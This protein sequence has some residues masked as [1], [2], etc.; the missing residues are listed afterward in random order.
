[1][2]F[3]PQSWRTEALRHALWLVA[4]AGPEYAL[5]AAKRAERESGGV[6]VGL[7]D[8]VCA[9]IAKHAAKESADVAP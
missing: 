2:P 6:L 9:A 4:R 3:N 7:A 5:D 8:K 1:M